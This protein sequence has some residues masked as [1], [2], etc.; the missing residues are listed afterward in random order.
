MY[1]LNLAICM[2][3]KQ[4]LQSPALPGRLTLYVYEE[5][6]NKEGQREKKR[7]GDA[8]DLPIGGPPMMGCGGVI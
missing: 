1:P 2:N 3:V 4:N 8:V 5:K 6:R 7:E